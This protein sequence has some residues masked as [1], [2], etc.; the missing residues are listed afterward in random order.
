MRLLDAEL[1]S[2][3]SVVSGKLVVVC[4]PAQTVFRFIDK[5]S[6]HLIVRAGAGEGFAREVKIIERFGGDERLAAVRALL[7]EVALRDDELL[8]LR[9]FRDGSD[10]IEHHR[11]LL[12]PAE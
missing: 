8:V 11:L 4:D 2:R 6:A 7:P 9:A 1:L 3:S 12:R 5:G 10:V